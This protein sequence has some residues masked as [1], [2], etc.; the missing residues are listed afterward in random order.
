M[1]QLLHFIKLKRQIKILLLHQLIVLNR[2]YF[3]NLY[4]F[5]IQGIYFQIH[6]QQFNIRESIQLLDY[7]CHLLR[8]IGLQLHFMDQK[9]YS[10]REKISFIVVIKLNLTSMI[11]NPDLRLFSFIMIKFG[12]STPN[13][14]MM[15]EQTRI[16]FSQPSDFHTL[17]LQ[18]IYLRYRYT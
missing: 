7:L 3:T 17:S 5:L 11:K 16:P 12:L 10:K 15:V 1:I 13:L 4:S 14:F 8:F 6:F 2:Y 18:Y 9:T